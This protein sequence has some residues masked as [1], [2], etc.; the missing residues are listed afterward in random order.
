MLTPAPDGANMVGTVYIPN[1]SIM[2]I[3]LVRPPWLLVAAPLTGMQGNVTMNLFVAKQMI[4][5]TSLQDLTLAPGNNTVQMRSTVNQTMVLNMLANYPSGILPIDVVGNSS[6]YNGQHLT[7]NE[8]AL[9]SNT[10]HIMLNVGA[11][12][13]AVE[14]GGGA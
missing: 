1:P 14:S 10:Q 6:V 12:L 2:T 13:A 9:A 4:G 5:T 3:E 7:Y 8:A 11:A